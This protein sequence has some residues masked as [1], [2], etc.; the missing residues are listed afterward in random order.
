MSPPADA[1][2]RER[3]RRLGLWGLLANWDTLSKQAWVREF[4]GVE[5]DE[6]G[7]RSLERRIRGA[8]LGPF[9]SIADFDWQ[10]PK[11]IDRDQIEDLTHE[12]RIAA[13]ARVQRARDRRLDRRL[14]GHGLRQPRH[15]FF[16]EPGEIH[17]AGHAPQPR[18]RRR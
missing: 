17:E 18:Q 9:K 15:L 13:R 3:A 8:R 10:W 7:R 11:S 12:Q 14:V 2:L 6:R 4:L 1:E 5:E 16:R